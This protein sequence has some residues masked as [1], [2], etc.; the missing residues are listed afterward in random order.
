M[1]MIVICFGFQFFILDICEQISN[2]KNS[3]ARKN[4]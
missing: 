3:K 2:I 4:K 1:Y